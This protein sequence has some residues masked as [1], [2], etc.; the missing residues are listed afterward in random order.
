MNEQT[1]HNTWDEFAIKGE[2]KRPLD[3][4]HTANSF[5]SSMNRANATAM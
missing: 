3:R 4:N 1:V 5:Q 2:K